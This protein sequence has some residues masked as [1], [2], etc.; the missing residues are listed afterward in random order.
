MQT[1]LLKLNLVITMLFKEFKSFKY[2]GLM[3]DNNLKFDIHV[4]FIKK[5]IQKSVGA[6]YV[7]IGD[8]VYYPLNIEK[9]LLTL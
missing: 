4:D 6:M 8:V 3:I 1:F 9:Y 5:K 7:C 2:L